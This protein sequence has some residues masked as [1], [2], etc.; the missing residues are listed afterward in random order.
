MMRGH[1]GDPASALEFRSQRLSPRPPPL[2][3][4]LVNCRR[5]KHAPL[6]LGTF[7]LLAACNSNTEERAAVGGLGGVIAG[8][9]LGGPIGAVAG[10][11]AGGAAGTVVSKAIEHNQQTKT[12]ADRSHHPE[13]T[14]TGQQQPMSNN[15]LIAN[16]VAVAPE[17]ELKALEAELAEPQSARGRRARVPEP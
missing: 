11:A 5:R 12:Q 4:R 14:G 3:N 17:A 16:A 13:D 6:A 10:G 15:Q 7:L 1:E 8:A 9:L 2:S